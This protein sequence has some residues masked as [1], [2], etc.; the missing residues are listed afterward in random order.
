[1][2]IILPVKTLDQIND[3]IS[4]TVETRIQQLKKD[5]VLL[6]F[7]EQDEDPNAQFESFVRKHF[8]DQEIALRFRGLLEIA[9]ILEQYLEFASTD[10][11][12]ER[13]NLRIKLKM[14][15]NEFNA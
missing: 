13:K 6:T 15:L 12:I 3:E 10:G 14:L 7:D 4:A 1:M 8:I 2:S 9:T 5:G 11:E